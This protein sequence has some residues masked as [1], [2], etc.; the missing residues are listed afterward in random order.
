MR[1]LVL[2]ADYPPRA[3]SGIGVAVE[4]Q[5]QAL[6]G[7]GIDVDVLAP[8]R[9]GWTAPVGTGPRLAVH[10]LSSRHCPIDPRD[11]D[12]VHLH[13]L[14]LS[15]FALELRRRLGLP[16][17]YTAHA[18]VHRELAGRDQARFWSAVQTAVLAASDHVVFLSAAERSAALALLPDLATRSSSIPHGLPPPA[19]DRPGPNVDGP[20]VF[21]GRFT[22][23]KGVDLLA[24]VIPRVQR[25]RRCR[26]ILAG[27]HGDGAGERVV[28]EV[29]D[30]F[31]AVCRLRGWLDRDELEAL[32]A[33]AGLVL[34]PSRYEPFGLVAL[35]AMRLGAP[36]LAAGVGGLAESVRPDSGGRLVEGHD[37]ETWSAAL[38]ELLAAPSLLAELRRRGPGYVAARF[39]LVH[40]TQRLIDSVY[41]PLTDRALPLR[42]TA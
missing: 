17:V 8:P 7:L 2:T 11:C 4:R 23:S 18:L 21:A 35:E 30:R 41:R 22:W 9:G 20:V 12:L 38:L 5:A 24:A 6:A 40:L 10:P 25:R 31:S 15:E 19:A 42:P 37:P 16:L 27:G 36:V 1:V 34:V 33:G 32:F 29:A 39:D 13:S 28:R 3:W 14:A 26:F